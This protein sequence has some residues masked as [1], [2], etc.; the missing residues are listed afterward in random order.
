MDTF[1]TTNIQKLN[2]YYGFKADGIMRPIP[3]A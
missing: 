3:L 2:K 1:N